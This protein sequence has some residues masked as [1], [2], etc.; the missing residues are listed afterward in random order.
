MIFSKVSLKLDTS[1]YNQ[2]KWPEVERNNLPDQTQSFFRDQ[3]VSDLSFPSVVQ[4]T[5]LIL[6]PKQFVCN[7]TARQYQPWT[8]KCHDAL[9]SDG[10]VE[11]KAFNYCDEV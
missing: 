5:T 1:L 4:W 2:D 11:V 9:V 7:F 10:A 6:S 8:G 3:V